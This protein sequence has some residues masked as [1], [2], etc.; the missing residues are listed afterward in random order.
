MQT[1]D[2]KTSAM[3]LMIEAGQ[4]VVLQLCHTVARSADKIQSIQ[5][6]DA[7]TSDQWGQASLERH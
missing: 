1:A 5:E 6:T 3:A 4:S 2:V 7:M